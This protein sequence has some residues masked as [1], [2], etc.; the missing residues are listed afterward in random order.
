MRRRDVPAG[1]G[2]V[3]HDET[4][5]DVAAVRAA[6]HAGHGSE[7]DVRGSHDEAL[8]PTLAFLAEHVGGRDI[9][10]AGVTAASPQAR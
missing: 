7:C 8:G 3:E 2:R 6:S 1:V 9:H 4:M 10:H 5:V